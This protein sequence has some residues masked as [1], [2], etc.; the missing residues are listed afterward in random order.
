MNRV[1]R[2][3]SGESVTISGIE[4][5]VEFEPPSLIRRGHP[6]IPVSADEAYPFP[7]VQVCLAPRQHPDSP[8]SHS[9]HRGMCSSFE[10]S[11]RTCYEN[12]GVS[13]FPSLCVR[14][15]HGIS[16]AL[17]FSAGELCALV[18]DGLFALDELGILFPGVKSPDIGNRLT[19]ISMGAV[20][21][22]RGLAAP[23]G[24][25]YRRLIFG[26]KRRTSKANRELKERLEDASVSLGEAMIYGRVLMAKLIGLTDKCSYPQAITDADRTIAEALLAAAEAMTLATDASVREAL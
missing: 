16:S 1:I 19:S 3:L 25:A 9:R 23:T 18:T 22:R 24:D 2:F 14:A 4:F 17:T 20:G 8:Q 6:P 13:Q 15:G 7:D 12:A 26:P 11:R 10:M 21:Y 5:A